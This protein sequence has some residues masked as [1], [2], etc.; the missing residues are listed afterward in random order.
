MANLRWSRPDLFIVHVAYE[1]GI[2][3]V[4]FCS[5][6]LFFCLSSIISSYMSKL[7]EAMPVELAGACFI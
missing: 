6:A 4:R 1:M 5:F 7:W 3:L 2:I